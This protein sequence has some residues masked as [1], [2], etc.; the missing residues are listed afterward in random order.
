[1]GRTSADNMGEGES[2]RNV[3]KKEKDKLVKKG[4]GKAELNWKKNTLSFSILIIK[5]EISEVLCYFFLQ[6]LILS[7]QQT[8][9]GYLALNLDLLSLGEYKKKSWYSI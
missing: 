9:W 1:M 2:V 6:H 7:V 5:W 4:N 3:Q 8:Q